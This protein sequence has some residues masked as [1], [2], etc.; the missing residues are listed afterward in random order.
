MHD[1]LCAQQQKGLRE[2]FCKPMAKLWVKRAAHTK[3][4]PLWMRKWWMLP[5]PMAS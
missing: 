5:L 1:A 3:M 4:L 2:S